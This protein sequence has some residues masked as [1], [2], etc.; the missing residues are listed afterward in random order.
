MIYGISFIRKS[1]RLENYSNKRR[2][3]LVESGFRM[4][5]RKEW[6]LQS[7]IF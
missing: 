3:N 4:K 1:E 6:K 2:K 7:E 5:K